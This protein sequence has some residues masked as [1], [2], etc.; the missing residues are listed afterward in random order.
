MGGQTPGKR[1]FGLRVIQ[2]NGQSATFLAVIIRNFF[3]LLD[4]LPSF[5]FLGVV[6]MLFSK[7]DKRIGDMVAGTI[8]VVEL[9]RE[10]LKRRKTMNK[11]IVSWQNRLPELHLED[12]GKRVFTAKD[13][14]IL[15]SWVER[16]PNMHSIRLE[17][18]GKPIAEYLA[19]KLQHPPE[20]TT[21]TQAYLI[22]LYVA[23]RE[24]WEV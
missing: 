15:S 21:N 3:R 22:A 4:V 16:L 11:A 13:W 2:D 8:V 9:Q 6:V 1:I 19:A 5:Y 24:D 12:T 20:V 18:L 17:E 10:R 14:L 7:K 23:L